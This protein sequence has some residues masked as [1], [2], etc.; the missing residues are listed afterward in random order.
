MREKIRVVRSLEVANVQIYP[1][2]TTGIVN[3]ST[4]SEIKVYSLQGAL[5]YETFGTQVD[6]S[7]Y[8]QGCT[9]RTSMARL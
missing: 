2:P 7:A 1:N 8:P 5:V 6:L 3:I 4:A 9:N